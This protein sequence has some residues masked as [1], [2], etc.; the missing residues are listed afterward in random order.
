LNCIL[1]LR[2]MMTLKVLCLNSTNMIL[3]TTASPN[4]I[5][6]LIILSASQPCSLSCFISNLSVSIHHE[7]KALQPLTLIQVVI[8]AN[9]QKDNL[10]EAKKF[11]HPWS[12]SSHHTTLAPLSSLLQSLPFLP[13]P[14][15][16][17]NT[18]P[19]LNY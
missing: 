8:F 9:L 18:S 14:K 12:P 4:S 16:H 1:R 19:Q 11:H 10:L 17:S 7:V 3:L 6:L 13:L 2:S 5:V 15:H